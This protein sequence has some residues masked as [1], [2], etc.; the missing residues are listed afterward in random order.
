MNLGAFIE[1]HRDAIAAA[2]IR[3][4]PPLYDAETRETCGFDLRRLLRRPLGGQADAIRATALSLAEPVEP[5]ALTQL[6]ASL[7]TAAWLSSSPG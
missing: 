2:V 7:A 5:R 3:T 1:R 4:Y 6:G